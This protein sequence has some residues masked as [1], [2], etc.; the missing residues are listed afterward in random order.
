ML[1]N[2]QSLYNEQYIYSSTLFGYVRVQNTKQ[3]TQNYIK[4]LL[5]GI[6]QGYSH[7][8][9]YIYIYFWHISIYMVL[10]FLGLNFFLVMDI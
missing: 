10:L 7:I 9:I 6:P 3:F 8:I 1:N 2:L 4:H 5:K